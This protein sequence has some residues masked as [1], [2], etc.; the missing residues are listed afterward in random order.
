[1]IMESS[2]F[3]NGIVTNIFW[4]VL[5]YVPLNFFFNF[6]IPQRKPSALC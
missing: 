1:M 3:K 2:Q 4:N 5:F 6:A